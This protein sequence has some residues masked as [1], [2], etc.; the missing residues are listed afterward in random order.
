[1]AAVVGSAAVAPVDDGDQPTVVTMTEATQAAGAFATTLE[2]IFG[3]DLV[4]AVLYGSAARG[5]H[6]P[7]ISDLNILVII[8]GLGMEHLKRATAAVAEW[9]S[10]GNPPPL[11]LSDLEWRS[12][13]DV[14]P[15]EYSDIRDAHI[16]LAG[17]DPFGAMHIHAEHLRLQLEHEL[18]SR[19][20]QLREG[21]L[22]VGD[23]PDQLGGLLMRSLPTFLALFRAAL[24]LADEPVPPAPESIVEAIAARADFNPAPILEVIRR[25]N[26]GHSLVTSLDGSVAPGFLHAIERAASWLDSFAAGEPAGKEI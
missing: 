18:R 16:L 6:R 7:G 21:F 10:A 24:R 4:A 14:F 17:L 12:S 13:A 8:R 11:M 20:I 23:S 25:R 2:Q 3:D 1:L 5:D 15:I 19:K 9:T 22:A 26:A